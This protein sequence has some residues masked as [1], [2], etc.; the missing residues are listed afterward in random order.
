[1][2]LILIRH[3]PAGDRVEWALS[4]RPDGDRPLTKEG[5]TKM[6][7]VVRGLRRVLESPERLFSSPLLRA[8]QTAELL[9]ERYPDLRVETAAELEPDADP[10]ATLAWLKS[11]DDCQRI[12]LVG[13]EPH[14]SGL[15]ALLVHSDPSLDTLPFRKGGVAILELD[16]IRPASARLTAFLPPRVL[17]ALG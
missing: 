15:L 17:R 5:S 11:L 6:R 10:A 8:R 4:G 7:R 14:L 1:M 16:A 9:L 3:A 2:Q 12:A 13:H